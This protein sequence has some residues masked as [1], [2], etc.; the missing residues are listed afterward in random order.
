MIR[1][2]CLSVLAAFLAL[3]F[4]CGMPAIGGA[5]TDSSAS[6]WH[7]GSARQVV[8]RGH[9]TQDISDSAISQSA[10]DDD[11]P[12]DN[13][14]RLVTAVVWPDCID[15]IAFGGVS[16]IVRKTHKPCAA[17]PRAPPTN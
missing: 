9:L 3:A 12:D 4:L 11:N 7:P 1:R 17:P 15:T 2:A 14:V 5:E 13:I 6:S 10:D 16:G 8:A